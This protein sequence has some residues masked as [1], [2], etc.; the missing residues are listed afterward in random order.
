MGALEELPGYRPVEADDPN[1]IVRS[2]LEIV[3]LLRGLKDQRELMTVYFGDGRDFIV[4][5]VLSVNPEFEEIVLDFGAEQKANARLMQATRL[6]MVS[7]LAHIKI[8][9]WTGGA[10]AT[11]FEELPAFRVRIPAELTRLQ[12]RQHYRVRVPVR[13]GVRCELPPCNDGQGRVAARVLDLSC[14]GAALSEVPDDVRL[15]PGTRL[16]GCTL[17][18]DDSGPI[19]ATFEI[20]RLADVPHAHGPAA[21]LVGVQFL[22]LSAGGRARIQR[23][24]NRIER[25]QIARSQSA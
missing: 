11:M 20:V 15:E 5:M 16:Q 2:R 21:R 6:L 3:S 1:F 13:H 25:E 22:D 14:G 19:E 10:D 9:F 4:T 7:Q 24:I 23:Y 12:R 8:Q 18:I 17:V